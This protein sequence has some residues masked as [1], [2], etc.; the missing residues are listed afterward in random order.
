MTI[1][2]TKVVFECLSQ[3]AHKQL[4]TTTPVFLIEIWG[5]LLPYPRL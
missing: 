2:E 3:L 4:D 5:S 1:G